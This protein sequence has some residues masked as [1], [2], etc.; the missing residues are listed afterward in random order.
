[1]REETRESLKGWAA[2]L[3]VVTVIGLFLAVL[4][5]F[6]SF[7]NGPVQQRIPYWVGMAW[8]GALVYG[9]AVRVV[10]A[11]RWSRTRGWLALAA[12]VL[13]STGPF[14]MFSF[15]VASS[16]WPVLK[17]APGLSPVV[18][19]GEGLLTAAPQVALFYA[20]HQR[21]RA[22]RAKAVGGAT[23]PAALLGVRS[24]D[25]L[26]LSMEDHY[27]RVHTA[28]GSNLVLAT[29]AQGIAAL[30]GAPGLQ[31]HRSWWVAEKAVAAAVV[32]GRNVRLRLT[33]GVLAPVART[34]VAAVRAAGWLDR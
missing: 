18:W 16:I 1:M 33:N 8:C 6:G 2:D 9:T 4:G 25:V 23:A 21:R 3:A 34:S 24:S 22:R 32:E 30:A 5:P 12:V 15:W 31:V 29:L 17:T 10:A 19:Y 27:V 14:A 26:C 13:I 7:F 20:L 28:T 11:Q